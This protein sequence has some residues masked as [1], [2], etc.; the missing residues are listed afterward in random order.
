MNSTK[1]NSLTVKVYMAT[2]GPE[3]IEIPEYC[4]PIEVGAALRKNFRYEIRDDITEDNV[5]R[6][7]PQ[8]SEA[9]ALYWMWKHD[10]SDIIGLYHY[11]RIFRLS[12]EQIIRYFE[13]Y[14]IIATYIDKD[15]SVADL[16]RHY[17]PSG[18]LEIT[19]KNIREHSPEYYESALD[20]LRSNWYYCCNLFVSRKS[21]FDRYCE[22]LFPLIQRIE[23]E[24]EEKEA[25]DSRY[26]GYVV[27]MILFNTYMRKHRFNVMH[28]NDCLL[29]K[30]GILGKAV[31]SG[32]YGSPAASWVKRRIPK[33][34]RQIFIR[35]SKY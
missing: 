5:S 29:G 35:S 8:W 16:F 20:V 31:Q 4:V 14:D 10:N 13:K 23:K 30:K 6:K 2:H 1:K 18:S 12:K 27:E 22:W 24:A 33:K 21:L 28:V 17:C 25:E 3:C 11:R 7:N 15:M 34:I 32:L 19:L 9:T 26:I